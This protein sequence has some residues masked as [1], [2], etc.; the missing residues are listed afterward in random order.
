[1]RPGNRPPPGSLPLPL[2]A[3]SSEHIYET[4]PESDSEHIY[5]E[6]YEPSADYTNLMPNGLVN[7]HHPLLT[8]RLGKERDSNVRRLA[9]PRLTLRYRLSV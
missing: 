7:G 2:R 9:F 8:L 6:P 1:M 5:C 4:I 3:P